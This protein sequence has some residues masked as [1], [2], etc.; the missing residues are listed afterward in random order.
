MFRVKVNKNN[1]TISEKEQMTAGSVNV[2][3]VVFEFSDDWDGLERVA[4]FKN[5]DKVIRFVLDETNTVQ[6]PWELMTNVGS[7]I[8]VGIRGM[9]GDE[10]VLPSVWAI[11][12]NVVE[13]VDDLDGIEA[14]PPPSGDN[15]E[16][17]ALEVEHLKNTMPKPM[18]AETLR[19]ILM[20]GV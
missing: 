10:V 1:V 13:S 18:S 3:P 2:Y 9:N 4:L 8:F 20:G 15:L 14:N 19:S 17:L 5:Q 12:G 11:C 16:S 7:K 6:M